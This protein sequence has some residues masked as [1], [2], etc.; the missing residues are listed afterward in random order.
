MAEVEDLLGVEDKELLQRF[1]LQL[2][3]LLIALYVLCF[4]AGLG[5]LRDGVFKHY[6][7]PSRHQIVS[8][9]PDTF[10]ILAWKDALG[11]V[12]TPDDIQVKLFPFAVCIFAVAEATVFAGIY[13]LLKG[14][15]A[16]MILIRRITPPV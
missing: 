3:I 10:E 8:M 1:S 13:Y 7:N 9:N 2:V 14:H 6:F 16:V 15:Y 5:F 12:Y 11:N 4:W